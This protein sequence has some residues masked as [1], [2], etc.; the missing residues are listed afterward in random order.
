MYSSSAQTS[1][2]SQRAH[3]IQK[4][5]PTCL[6]PEACG[7]VVVKIYSVAP[8]H[9]KGVFDL[10]ARWINGTAASQIFALAKI[11]GLEAMIQNI[12]GDELMENRWKKSDRLS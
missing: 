3:E 12:G 10:G 1:A 2:V 5:G 8:K 9:G 6:V 4:V 11:L 7:T